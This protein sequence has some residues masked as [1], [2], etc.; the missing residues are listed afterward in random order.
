MSKT[1]RFLIADDV[2]TMRKVV[3]GVLIS[4]GYTNIT[5]A[6]DGKMALE[7]LEICNNKNEPI[8]FIISDWDMPNMQGIDLLRSC[9][10]SEKY[11]HLPF[12]LV[13][14]EGE[15]HN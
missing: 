10:S 9:R 15:Q 2:S 5:E 14:A 4:L 8:E 7:V 12:I 6:S 3:K 1:L 11:K 13:T